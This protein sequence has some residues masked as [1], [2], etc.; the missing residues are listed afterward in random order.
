MTA[1]LENLSPPDIVVATQ[2]PGKLEEL[3]PVKAELIA[4][5]NG[6]AGIY[7]AVS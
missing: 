4:Y 5:A 6:P 7:E 3:A 2:L 1:E